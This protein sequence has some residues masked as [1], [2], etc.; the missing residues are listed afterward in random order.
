MISSLI[1][2]NPN[3]I[4]KQLCD[5]IIHLYESQ[6]TQYHG[7]TAGGLNKLVKDTMDFNI[8]IE[9]PWTKIREFLGLELQ[10]NL[11]MYMDQ[12]NSHNFENENS[13][14]KFKFFEGMC[15]ST[16]HFMIQR[17]IKQVGRYIYHNDSS[18]RYDEKRYRIITFLWYLN[19]VEEGGETELW[20]T[21]KIKPEAGKLILFPACWTMPHTGKMPIS[22]NKYII[23]GWLYTPIDS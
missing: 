5:E 22:D 9:D 17:Y 16:D 8:P 4:S 11:K 13:P 14:V 12:L 15:C 23:T 1:Y 10:R 7:V 2:L 6:N 19:T 21:H 3:S 18:I 20:G